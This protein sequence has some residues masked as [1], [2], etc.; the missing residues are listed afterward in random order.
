M[1]VFCGLF[2]GAFIGAIMTLVMRD[3]MDAEARAAGFAN[4]QDKAN[5]EARAA[6]FANWQAKLNFDISA[7][8]K[9]RA[10]PIAATKPEKQIII[11][12]ND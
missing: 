12:I 9:S 7:L 8:D 5:A 10:S 11:G 2:I 3:G 6:G 1:L 4:W